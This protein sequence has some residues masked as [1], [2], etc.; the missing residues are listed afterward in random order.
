MSRKLG[1]DL[2]VEIVVITDASGDHRDAVGT[3]VCL[4]C[5]NGD[6]KLGMFSLRNINKYVNY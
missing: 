6:N 1:N 3:M 2:V 4:Y 5:K